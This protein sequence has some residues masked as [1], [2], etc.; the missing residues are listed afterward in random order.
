[1][2]MSVPHHCSSCFKSIPEQHLVV[3]DHKGNVLKRN[4]A[5]RIPDF[6][7]LNSTGTKGKSSA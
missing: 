3:V 5:P 7:E 2:Q 1:M 6:P 4:G